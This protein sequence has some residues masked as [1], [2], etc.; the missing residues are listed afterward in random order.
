LLL[1]A[2][3]MGRHR[4]GLQRKSFRNRLFN[5]PEQLKCSRKH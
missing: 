1:L 5:A 2:L 4:V 3:G